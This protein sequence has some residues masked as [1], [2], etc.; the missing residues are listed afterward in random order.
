[1]ALAV[2]SSGDAGD[3]DTKEINGTVTSAIKTSP[4]AARVRTGNDFVFAVIGDYGDDDDDTRRV[5]DM[6]LGWNTDFIVTVGDNDY[7]DG[8]HAGTMEGMELGVGQFFHECIGNYQGT[9]GAGSAENRFFPVPGDHDWGDNCDNPAA[10]DDYLAYF[11][12]P[13]DGPGGERY[14][15]FR[16]GPVQFFAIDSPWGCDPD[17][18]EQDSAQAQWVRAEAAASDALFKVAVLHHAPYTSGH[19]GPEDGE[20]VQWPWAD[21]GFDLVLSGHDHDYERLERD[22]VTYIVNGLGGVDR[23]GF[24]NTINGSLV[25]YPD[26]YGAMQ[27]TVTDSAI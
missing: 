22:G 3:E 17:G 15:Q 23:R 7:S 1:M 4:T 8:A 24:L 21:W 16:H 18:I 26:N 20:H 14:Y 9:Y 19:H 12:L 13:D 25:R 5:A 27:I 6:F 2:S 10:L 11:T